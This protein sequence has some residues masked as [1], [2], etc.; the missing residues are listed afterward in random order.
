MKRSAFAYAA[1]SPRAHG[2]AMSSPTPYTLESRK[3]DSILAILILATIIQLEAVLGHNPK[4]GEDEQVKINLR[5]FASS[6]IHELNVMSKWPAVITIEC[7]WPDKNVVSFVRTI[8]KHVHIN[9]PIAQNCL[10][11]LTFFNI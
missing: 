5:S 7:V 11:Y 8:I 10:S 6:V 4:E 2:A 3:A 1:V 9:L